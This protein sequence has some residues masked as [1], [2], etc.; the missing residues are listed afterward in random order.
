MKCASTRSKEAVFV[1]FLQR[2]NCCYIRKLFIVDLSISSLFIRSNKYIFFEITVHD[3][4][5]N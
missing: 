3:N 4:M 5:E 2:A 1:F